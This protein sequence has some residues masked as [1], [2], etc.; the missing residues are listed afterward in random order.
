MAKNKKK[1]PRETVGHDDYF[2]S[3]AF[4][5]AS[6]SKDP[7]R[8]EGAV[9]VDKSHR[10]ISAEPNGIPDD[11]RDD[12]FS[13]ERVERANYVERAVENAIYQGML[14]IR[15]DDATIYVTSYPSKKCMRSV[16]RAK[17][18]RVVWFPLHTKLGLTPEV[19]DKDKE[20][21]EAIAKFGSI[22]L[23]EFKGNLNWMRDQL[24]KFEEVGIF[25]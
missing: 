23:D 6:T 10:V 22:K 19:S 24:A 3:L 21:V 15:L 16:C 9:I 13:W 11:I 17:L 8:Q 25:K 12:D 20:A 4:W 1:P 5:T 7:H 18:D 2:M 14:M